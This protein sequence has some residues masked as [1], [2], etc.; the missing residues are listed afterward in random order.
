MDHVHTLGLRLLVV[1]DEAMVAMLIEDM[2]TELGCVIVDIA[3]SVSKAVRLVDDKGEMLDG[4]IL[5]V[6]L[7]GE[8]VFPVADA[9]AL[10][11]VPF[12]FA[13]GYGPAGLSERYP[14]VITLTKPFRVSALEQA[15]SVLR[16]SSESFP[17]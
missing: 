14:G 9:L 16:K 8:K 11:G 17:G 3:P 1:E 5:D 12:L 10:R 4:A 15:L 6:N 7:G 13:T 2:L